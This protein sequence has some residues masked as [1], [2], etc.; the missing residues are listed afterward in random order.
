MVR[1]RAWQASPAKAVTKVVAGVVIVLATCASALAAASIV[2][3]THGRVAGKGYVYWL[4]REWQ[5]Q[6]AHPQPNKACV[7]MTVNGRQVGYLGVTS[8]VLS[9]AP[10]PFRY[11]CSEPAGRPLYVFEF[12]FEC[13]TF[14]GDH[15]WSIY[16]TFGTS[17]AQ[18]KLCARS[19]FTAGAP[20]Q[21]TT[22]DGHVVNVSKLLA[23]TDVFPV[24]SASGQ[25]PAQSKDTSVASTTTAG[26][27]AA[28]GWGLLLTGLMR[29]TH[30]IHTVG[31]FWGGEYPVSWAYTWKI[32]VH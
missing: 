12:S 8:T 10:G 30:V 18:L 2:V 24:H 20:S 5:Y 6:F 26:R 19:Y 7:T 14:P 25:P 11:T 9:Q 31:R 17:N 4:Q 27:S 13:S 1:L 32:H 23:V 28:Y 15:G 3:P 22:I 29:G 21:T 16:L